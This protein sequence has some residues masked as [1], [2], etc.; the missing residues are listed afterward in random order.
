MEN[1][2]KNIDDF[3]TEYAACVAKVCED[4]G[5]PLPEA[6]VN[7]LVTAYVAGYNHVGETGVSHTFDDELRTCFTLTKEGLPE[8]NNVGKCM[9]RLSVLYIREDNVLVNNYAW[10]G[11]AGF[12]S[13]PTFYFEHQLKNVIA[14][15]YDD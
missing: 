15:R 5:N 9:R 6:F 7:L 11:I 10:Y 13:S 4:N 3:A 8:T 14:W 1:Q 12:F 2:Q